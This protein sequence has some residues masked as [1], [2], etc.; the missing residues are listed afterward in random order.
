M[1]EG[2]E[3]GSPEG[4]LEN[5]AP[6]TLWHHNITTTS[7]GNNNNNSSDTEDE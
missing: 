4:H 5:V 3:N 7:D 2:R 6:L 1:S